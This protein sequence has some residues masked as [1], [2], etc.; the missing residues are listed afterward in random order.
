M[1]SKNRIAKELL[2]IMLKDIGD[3]YFIDAF[4][5]GG[6][7]IQHASCTN[8]IASDINKYTISFLNKI[9]DDISWVPKSEAEFSKDDYMY[10]KNN[11]EAFSDFMLGHVGYNLSFGGR[12][13]SGWSQ[14]A[15]RTDY[16]KAAYENVVRQA[17]KIK[18][19]KFINCSYENLSIPASSVVYCDIP[20][21][22]TAT[23]ARQPFD[24][25]KF[26]DWCRALHKD[27]IKIFVS[28][29]SMPEDFECVWRKEVRVKLSRKTNSSK[30]TE[31]LFTLRR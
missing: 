23:Y 22:N 19:V 30:A 16:I 8:K 21:K 24:Y 11:K 14:N 6:N 12:W 28:E 3:N 15:A 25:E 1:G 17:A 18:D 4:T 10:M 2:G 13:F 26:Y 31:K 20:Y 5:G 7:L 27:R 9:K 29:Y